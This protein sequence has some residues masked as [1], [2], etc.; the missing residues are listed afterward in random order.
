[1]G[2]IARSR[3][4]KK[5]LAVGIGGICVSLAALIYT[6]HLDIHGRSLDAGH[7]S[8]ISFRSQAL[9]AHGRGVVDANGR[10][11]HIARLVPTDARTAASHRSGAWNVEFLAGDGLAG[12]RS[13][14]SRIRN[15]LL[16]DLGV[17]HGESDRVRDCTWA[18]ASAR[19]FELS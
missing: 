4:W 2:T 10:F 16:F 11:D 8:S 1:M 9:G 12:A 6:G 5:R 17:G 14:S 15:V 18:V 13:E 7:Q 3:G 19:I